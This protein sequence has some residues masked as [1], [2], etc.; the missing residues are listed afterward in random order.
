M[1]D[2]REFV[3]SGGAQ[4]S[5]RPVREDGLDGSAAAEER[6][7]YHRDAH[8]NDR[9]HASGAPLFVRGCRAGALTRAALIAVRLL[10]PFAEV[11]RAA[12]QA[13]ACVNSG[14]SNDVRAREADY[15]VGSLD[16][17]HRDK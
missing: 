11:V 4:P 12:G 16:R 14:V 7:T 6:D 5:T 17:E 15:F 13:R 8:M 1:L 9:N 2:N 10:A 3:V